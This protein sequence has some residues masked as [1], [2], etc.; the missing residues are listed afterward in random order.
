MTPAYFPGYAADH[1]MAHGLISIRR[2]FAVLF[3]LTVIVTETSA[4]LLTDSIVGQISQTE[5]TSYVTRLQNYPTR[6][7][8]TAGNASAL[9]Y[10]SDEFLG[11][12]LS[13]A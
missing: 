7:Y 12:G 2:L 9:G 11:Y 4:S 5:Y 13:V 6:Y 8:N 1:P 3:F 10:I